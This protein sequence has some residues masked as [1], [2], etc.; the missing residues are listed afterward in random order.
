MGLQGKGR[1]MSLFPCPHLWR[2]LLRPAHRGENRRRSIPERTVRTLMVVMLAEFPELLPR[3]VQRRKPLHVQAF[4]SQPP[5]ETLD[6]SVL[7]G[8][9]WPNEAQLHIVCHCPGLQRTARELAAIIHGN[10][11]RQTPALLPG[12]FQR[13]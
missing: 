9:T 6:K 13:L 12:A 5:V 4:V 8:T 11:F 3:I 2:S 10:A 1:H 7:H